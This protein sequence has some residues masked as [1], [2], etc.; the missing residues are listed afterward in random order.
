LIKS[1][2]P[3]AFIELGLKERIIYTPN[4]PDAKGPQQKKGKENDKA[5]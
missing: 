1:Q 3:A 5:E 4:K 2:L